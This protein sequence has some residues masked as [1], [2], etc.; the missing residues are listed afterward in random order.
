[1]KWF[2]RCSFILLNQQFF[3]DTYDVILKRYD[4]VYRSQVSLMNGHYCRLIRLMKVCEKPNM[5]L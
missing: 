1:M 4:F 5:V 2:C 3:F